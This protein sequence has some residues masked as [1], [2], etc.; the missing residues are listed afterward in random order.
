MDR[1]ETYKG[2]IG[3][4][5]LFISGFLLISV[6][7]LVC[8]SKPGVYRVGVLSGINFA[9]EITDGFQTRMT[10]LG[11]IEGKNITYDVQKTDFDM[12]VYG[13]IL[14]HY[15]EDNVDLIFV[16][17]TE[18]AMLAKAATEGTD[19]PVV[20]ANSFTEDTGLVKSVHEPGGNIT[21]VRWPGPEIVARGFE[22]FK[23]LVPHMK[24]MLLPYQ[25]EYFPRLKSQLD[26]LYSIAAS[27]SVTLIEIPASHPGELND[28][29]Q[30]LKVPFDAAV[31][32]PLPEPLVITSGGFAVVSKFAAMHNILIGGPP[33]FEGDYQGVFG[34]IP[35]FF[36][37]GRQAAYLADKIFKGSPAGTLPVLTSDNIL[38][39]NYRQAEKQKL[40]I[41]ESL[42]SQADQVLR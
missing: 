24:Y 14:K 21:G 40:S 7:S 26:I 4:T 9:A 27:E 34:I 12:A 29:L 1:G 28:E 32:H 16:F 20:F 30:K 23:E 17:P 25:R 3:G 35:P 8:C 33:F 18:A 41:P 22:I 15:V 42:L 39:L 19:I 10:E 37:Q 31:I 2:K 36:E 13:R 38:I 5:C 6:L 11:Y